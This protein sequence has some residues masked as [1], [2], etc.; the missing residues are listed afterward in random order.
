VIR[1]IATDVLELLDPEDKGI[2]ML[3][4]VRNHIRI[5]LLLILF[6]YGAF[7][8]VIFILEI[9]AGVSIY[10]YRDNLLDGFGKGLNQSLATYT[11]DQQKASDFDLMQSTVSKRREGT[12]TSILGRWRSKAL[13]IKLLALKQGYVQS[14]YSKSCQ[15]WSLS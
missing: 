10:A 7:L 13:K 6:Q 4:N 14:Q 8:T 3:R 12:G 9:S 11:T 2:N 5:Q 1:R 15:I